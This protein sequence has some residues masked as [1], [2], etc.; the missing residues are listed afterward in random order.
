MVSM[1]K[2]GEGLINSK[3]E[4]VTSSNSQCLEGPLIKFGNYSDLP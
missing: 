4:G 3:F 1:I 2:L